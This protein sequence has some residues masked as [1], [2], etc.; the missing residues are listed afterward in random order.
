MMINLTKGNTQTIYFTGTEKANLSAPYFL[1]VFNN[2]VTLEQVKIMATNT[3]TTG[4][5][6]SFSLVVNTSFGNSETGFWSYNI[7]EKASNV[8]LAVTGN[9]VESGMMYLNPATASTVVEYSEQS[10]DFITYDGQ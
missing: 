2:R 10:N 4:R 6:D 1:F 5:Y 9:I 3:S 7:Y 8:D